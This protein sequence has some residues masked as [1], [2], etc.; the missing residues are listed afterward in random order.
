M[1]EVMVIQGR[2]LHAEDI[3]LIRSLLAEHG[4]GTEHGSARSFA[5][6]GT[7]AM[8]AKSRTAGKNARH[9]LEQIFPWI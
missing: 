6:A 5:G 7:G 9:R 8:D 1:T 4:T 3:G 2:E